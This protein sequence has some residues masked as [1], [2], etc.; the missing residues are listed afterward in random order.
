MPSDYEIVYTAHGQLDAEMIKVLLESNGIQASIAGE[1]VG[2]AYGIVFGPL[3]DMDIL[4]PNSQADNARSILDAM[5]RG[6]LDTG[7]E[8]GTR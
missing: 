5:E 8:P 7:P 1:S 4:V 2:T 3:G 6:D